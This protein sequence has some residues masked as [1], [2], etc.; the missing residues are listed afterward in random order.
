MRP[1]ARMGLTPDPL[2]WR[3]A[4]PQTVSL[5]E[6]LDIPR[7]GVEAVLDAN[8]EPAYL[9]ITGTGQPMF[10]KLIPEGELEK[11]THAFSLAASLNDISALTPAPLWRR[12]V[13][14]DRT[15][16]AYAWTNG[17]H[18][19]PESTDFR[20]LGGDIAV[21]H[22]TLGSLPD[23]GWIEARTARR[24]DALLAAMRDQD[25]AVLR[26]W[27]HWEPDA[28]RSLDAFA[29]LSPA[30]RQQGVPIHGDLNPG[31]IL[32]SSR[33]A[34]FLDLEDATHSALWPGLDLAKIIE[35]LVL[36]EIATAGTDWAR[37]SIASL[38]AGYKANDGLQLCNAA[39]LTFKK[40]LLW[41]IGLSVTLLTE[42]SFSEE[43]RYAEMNKF[44]DLATLVDQHSDLLDTGLGE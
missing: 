38:L 39:G 15:A 17:R 36:P 25:Q 13:N 21:L 31:N 5:I 6:A 12:E 1:P 34:I 28:R 20:L 8:D 23:S 4:G 3:D 2:K 22:R 10:I 37:D 7:D 41:H 40:A 43:V 18:P 19:T 33:K 35:R 32:I 9:R 16:F 24:I 14:N 29:E 30:I 27:R 42:G 11:E 44:S 26:M